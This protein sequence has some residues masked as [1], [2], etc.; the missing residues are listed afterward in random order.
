MELALDAWIEEEEDYYYTSVLQFCS[1]SVCGNYT[2]VSMTNRA[3]QA[4][5][6]A[7]D[8]A[9]VCPSLR[10]SVKRKN[11]YPLNVVILLMF[12]LLA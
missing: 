8:E 5:V 2:Q 11:G 12:A 4:C 7:I 10:P 1:D 9:S 3:H 6:L